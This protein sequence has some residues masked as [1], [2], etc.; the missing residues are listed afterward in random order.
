MIFGPG[1]AAGGRTDRREDFKVQSKWKAKSH[2][3]EQSS[4]CLL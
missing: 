3:P 4:Q 2:L 1:Q